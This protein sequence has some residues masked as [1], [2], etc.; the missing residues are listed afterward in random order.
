MELGAEQRAE[1]VALVN[2]RDVVANV[3][4]RVRIVLRHADG[5]AKRR[6]V[7]LAGVSR[8]TVD[9]W[10]RRYE[11]DGVAGLVDRPRGAGCEQVPASVRARIVALTRATPPAETGLS[12]WSSRELATYVSRTGG[13]RVSWHYVAKVWRAEGLRPHRQGTFELSRDPEF[14]TKVA[15]IVGLYLD[16]PG[17]AVVLC[18]DEKTQVQALDRTQPLLPISFGRT[19]KRTHDYVRHGTTNLFAALDAATGQVYGECRPVRDGAA[20]LAFLTKAVAPHAGREIH[21]V[22]D[23]LS[24]HT[25][26]DVNAWLEANPHVHFHFTPVGSSWINQIEIWFGIITRQAI[27]RGTFP[28]VHALTRQIRDYITHWNTDA[29]PFTWTATADEILAKVRLTQTSIRKLVANNRR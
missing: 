6:I 15:D 3:A 9:L 4:T 24:T 17:G 22:L 21:I 20:F 8:P 26:P 28:S 5:L 14:A 11:T 13:V 10:L 1:L 27:R 18:V 19:E 23:N 29:E 2:S 12:H 25:T 7:E 16:P